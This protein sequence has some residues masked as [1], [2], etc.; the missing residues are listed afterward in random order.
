MKMENLHGGLQGVVMTSTA[1]QH[2]DAP[3]HQM[4]S[5]DK[6]GMCLYNLGTRSWYTCTYQL[7]GCKHMSFL[8]NWI[9]ISKEA[10]SKDWAGEV[11]FGWGSQWAPPSPQ[12]GK[13]LLLFHAHE[14]VDWGTAEKTR[15]NGRRMKKR[16]ENKAGVVGERRGK[17][18][19][20][21]WRTRRGRRKVLGM[22]DAFPCFHVPLLQGDSPSCAF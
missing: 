7:W 1:L 14:S 16:A 2:E 6:S 12:L 22:G 20:G 10:K 4:G 9:F 19:K 13:R 18:S 11:D 21:G 3:R 5:W 8:A 15:R 17:G